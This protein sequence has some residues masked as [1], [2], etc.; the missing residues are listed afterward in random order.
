[1]DRAQ[2]NIFNYII[3]LYTATQTLD[4][5]TSSQRSRHAAT[6]AQEQAATVLHRLEKAGIAQESA[7][8]LL[9]LHSLAQ[10]LSVSPQSMQAVLALRDKNIVY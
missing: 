5:Q 4:T 1:M 7:A 6:V 2:S 3:T 8:T 10:Q 9:L